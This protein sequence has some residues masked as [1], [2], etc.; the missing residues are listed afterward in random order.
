MSS[1]IARMRS[2]TNL[3][4]D[5]IRCRIY[6]TTVPNKLS[7]T[8]D[9]HGMRETDTPINTNPVRIRTQVQFIKFTVIRRS[10]RSLI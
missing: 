3:L 7:T 4:I 6:A 8:F 10:Q 2:S 1:K 9:I 5:I